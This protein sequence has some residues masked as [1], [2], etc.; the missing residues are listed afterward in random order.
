[1]TKSRGIAPPRARNDD[2]RFSL[3]VEPT[4]FCWLWTGA[5]DGKG[6]GRVSVGGKV[7]R[8]HRWAYEALVGPIPSGLHLDHLCRVKTCVNP[9]HLE[10]VT[11]RVNLERGR[12][13]LLRAPK[14]HCKHGHEYD[15]KNT[16]INSK[17]RKVCRACDRKRHEFGGGR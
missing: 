16:R 14:T 8:A 13:V 10:P 6:Y 9:D 15:E 3:Y 2:D 11:H 5:L 1:M 12:G 4:G 7:V 17:G